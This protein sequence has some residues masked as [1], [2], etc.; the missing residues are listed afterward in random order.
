MSRP[1]CKLRRV[2]GRSAPTEIAM[3]RLCVT[4]NPNDSGVGIECGM[5]VNRT[6]QPC[7][8]GELPQERGI[9]DDTVTTLKIFSHDS[10]D[11]LVFARTYLIEV[12]LRFA[13]M[14]RPSKDLQQLFHQRASHSVFVNHS[15]AD[16]T[17]KRARQFRFSTTRVATYQDHLR[18][19]V[20][21]KIRP[22]L[23]RGTNRGGLVY[24]QSRGVSGRRESNPR[25]QFGRLRSMP[26]PPARSEPVD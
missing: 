14:G 24:N 18:A 19:A 20:A 2:P 3:H 10:S 5:G 6:T 1:I 21:Q 23:P 22:P 13:V 16:L 15:P 9:S 12:N 26:C 8:V 17:G 7:R 11:R 25:S 4:S